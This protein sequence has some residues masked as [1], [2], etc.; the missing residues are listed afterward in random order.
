MASCGTFVRF[1]LFLLLAM[2]LYDSGVDAKPVSSASTWWWPRPQPRCTSPETRVEWTTLSS[3]Q[4]TAYFNAELCLYA[5]PA[6]T[7]IPGVVSR[8]DDLVGV[9]ST[10]SNTTDL[11]DL[12]HPT[13]Q[14]LAVHRYY[15]HTHATLLRREC[16]YRGPIPYWNEVPDAGAF[17]NSTTIL[18]FGGEGEESSGYIVPSGPFANLTVHLGPG[19][20]NTD[21][22]LTRKGDAR[23]SLQVNQTYVDSV[24][25]A[26]TFA[27]FQN[28]LSRSL[29]G[30]G[31]GGI[32]GDMINI[33]TAP[34]D[35]LFWMHHG[36]LD[37]V[38]WKWQGRNMT[39]IHDLVG[40]GNETGKAPPTGFVATSE[41][42]KLYA[43]DLIANATVGD[44]VDTQGGFLCYTYV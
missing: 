34:N 27:Q 16:G 18:D 32:G 11:G 22:R 14:F 29:H 41:A 40:A 35:P 3:E 25:S 12:W 33:L 43:Y 5:A 26:T 4:K 1:T 20:S 38:W 24:M 17:A 39:R 7:S 2:G 28:S 10:Q 44:V 13:G 9:H 31:H 19:M 42:T 37:Y 36:Y 30:A 15:V 8:Y 23:N 21:H 6:R